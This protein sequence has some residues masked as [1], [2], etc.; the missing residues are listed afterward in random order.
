MKYTTNLQLK[1]PD[2]V[3]PADIG[4]LN[5]NMDIVDAE[6]KKV[7]SQLGDYAQLKGDLSTLKTTAK[8]NIPNIVN[9][10]FTNVSDGKS[11]VGG[12]ITDV[13]ASVIIPAEPTFQQLVDGIRQ[14]ST[15]KK[16][17]SGN[18]VS[19]SGGKLTVSGLSFRPSIVIIAGDELSSLYRASLLVAFDIGNQNLKI[20]PQTFQ[21]SV[22]NVWKI[23]SF[24]QN[25]TNVWTGHKNNLDAGENI[26][27]SGFSYDVMFVSRRHNWLAIE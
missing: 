25:N 12:A 13:D 15:G 2:Y 4:I 3:D 20:T 8:D 26:N 18:K 6:L 17:A 21:S 27:A 7:E 24:N 14:I 10:L 11:L 23:I 9:E 1:K 16:W 22:S 19:S 5:E